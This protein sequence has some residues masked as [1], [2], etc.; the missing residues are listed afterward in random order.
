MLDIKSKLGIR[1]HSIIHRLA[2]CD[3]G[4]GVVCR[5]ARIRKQHLI[6]G[7]DRAEERVGHRLLRSARYNHAGPRKIEMRVL[8][9]DLIPKRR[10]AGM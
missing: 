8:L 6:T 5:E 9:G 3:S 10:N 1:R 4:A 2:L 7:F